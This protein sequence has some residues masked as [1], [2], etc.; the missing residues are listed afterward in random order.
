MKYT[1]E[2]IHEASPY[3]LQHAHNPV[4]WYPWGDKAFEKAKRE[5]KMLII[6]IGYAACHWCHVMEH[7]SF[8][9]EDV[10]ALMNEHFVS[11]KVD[12]EERP[13]VDLIYMNAAQLIHG[14]GGWPLN[15][16]ALPDGSP[17]FAAT[18]FPPDRWVQ[19]L[20]YFIQEFKTNYKELSDQAA[21]LSAG[22]A[23]VDKIP[24]VTGHDAFSE[25]DIHQIKDKISG[26]I[27]WH[28]GGLASKMKFPMPSV[29]E[30]L[31]QYY[32]LTNDEQVL[33][34]VTLT[35]D[36]MK[37]GGIYDQIGGGFARYATDREWHVPHFEKMLY[38]NA[39]LISLYSHAY[40]VTQNE[41]YRSVVHETVSF[42]KRELYQG[43]RFYSSLDADSEKEEGKYYVWT[44]EEINQILG[45]DARD[46]C[47]WFGITP[48]G[49]WEHGKNIPDRNI[50]KTF[51]DK[52]PGLK[53][54][55]DKSRQKLFE[56]RAKRIRP[57][58]DDKVITAWNAMT[59]SAL[60][61]AWRALGEKAFLDLAT[62][63]LIFLGEKL[64]DKEHQILFRNFK[65]NKQSTKGLLDDYAFLIKAFI[66]FYQVSFEKEYLD[67]ANELLQTVL[68]HF[69]DPSNGL[70]FYNDS[71]FNDLI[72]RPSELSDGVIPASNSVM[73]DNLYTLGLLLDDK[74]MINRSTDMLKTMKT[75]MLSN[76]LYQCYMAGVLLKHVFPPFEVAIVGKEFR[77]KANQMQK[78]YLPFAEFCGSS[79]DENLPLL[80]QKYQA[81]KTLIYVCKN[82]TCQ[83]PV[84]SADEALTQIKIQISQS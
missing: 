41:E 4:N 39:Q 57:A 16:L 36:K 70:F 58:T 13:D 60:L 50:G 21:H 75:E 34:G 51:I 82:K 40:Q 59:C 76:P 73:A 62:Q 56:E 3:L 17:F 28:E 23:Q 53:A 35:L 49:N 29:W 72:S 81:D 43:N 20:K 45:E 46:F 67:K 26:A 83:L 48:S 74:S 38:D 32:Y 64:W 66:D 71:R 65:H 37:D 31:L 30:W 69:H 2:L 54:K 18:Y 79:S 25:K 15:A 11:I 8:E 47:S 12:R 44:Y 77:L 14:S 68:T 61:E 1:N 10:A 7:E 42:L 19:L 80:E 22:I 27:D 52:H 63:N 55:I 33:K 78:Y 5:N 84:S 9:D 6:S 24:A